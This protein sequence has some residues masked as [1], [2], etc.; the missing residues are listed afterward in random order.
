VVADING[1]GETGGHVFL[2]TD[3]LA[4]A[5]GARGGLFTTPD[6]LWYGQTGIAIA[7]ENIKVNFGGPTASGS[8]TASGYALGGGAEWPLPATPLPLSPTTAS[9]FVDYQHIWWD[10]GSLHM[11]SAV[12]TLNFRWQRDGNTL[13]A[14]LRLHFGPGPIPIPSRSARPTSSE[15]F[16]H[17]GRVAHRGPAEGRVRAKSPPSDS[18]DRWRHCE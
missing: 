17:L 18:A 4:S 10:D 11:P 14:G 8:R 16:V 12:S 5:A 7:D 13:K 9:L 1:L 3:N 2:A 15:L 6:L